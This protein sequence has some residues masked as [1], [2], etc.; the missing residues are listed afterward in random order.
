LVDDGLLGE[1]AE[2]GGFRGWGGLPL[3]ARPGEVDVEEEEEDAKADYGG[4]E[5]RRVLGL[6]CPRGG[7][8]MWGGGGDTNGKLV[9]VF[10]ERVVEK[11]SVD[12]GLDQDEIDEENDKV[13]LDVL[14]AKSAAVLAHCQANV[15][16]AGLVTAALAP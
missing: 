10:H 16:P 7:S 14:V 1:A 11:V 5:M 15:V 3:D 12:L 4:L 9:L 2:R 8:G 13:V 6:E